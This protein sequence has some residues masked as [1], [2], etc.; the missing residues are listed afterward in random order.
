MNSLYHIIF[1]RRIGLETAWN[2]LEED[3]IDVLY[4]S[5]EEANTILYAYLNFPEKILEKEE[6]EDCI[7]Y[8]L[9]SIDWE[10]QWKDHS[11]NFHDGFA[12]IHLDKF[13]INAPVV[14]LEPG[15]GFGDLSH[16]T[17]QLALEL[18]AKEKNLGVVVDIGCGSGILSLAAAAFGAKKVYGI[19][20]DQEAIDHSK[21]NSVINGFEER[22]HFMKPSKLNWKGTQGPLVIVMNMIESEQIVAW[23]SLRSLHNESAK[24]ITT[25]IPSEQRENYLKLTE[26][27]NW[28]LIKEI[29]REG[30]CAFLWNINSK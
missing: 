11:E 20:I 16:V 9:P 17:T 18:L 30:W 14:R 8:S 26:S 23:N 19:D 7:V 2:I 3:G 5:E 24:C 25:G 10:S 28:I 13:D 1:K 21:K 29:Q 4:G 12:H 6:V 22:C 15:P 27:W